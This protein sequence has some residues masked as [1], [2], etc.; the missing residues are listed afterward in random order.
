MKN[1]NQ[2]LHD[3]LKCFFVL[4][5]LTFVLFWLYKT[6][7][8]IFEEEYFCVQAFHKLMLEASVFR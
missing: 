3:C 2:I 4:R 8:N 7:K 6:H 5:Y 1:F